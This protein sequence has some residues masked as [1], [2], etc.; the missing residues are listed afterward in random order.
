[1]SRRVMVISAD[2]K[3]IKSY[4]SVKECAFAE[5]QKY[6]TIGDN[7]RKGSLNEQTNHFYDYEIDWVDYG[8]D[9]K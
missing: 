2:G 7:I 3:Y 6:E 9:A 5:G 8:N 4:P 1:M